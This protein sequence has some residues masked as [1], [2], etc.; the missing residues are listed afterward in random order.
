MSALTIAFSSTDNGFSLAI[1][2]K[3][4]Q[5]RNKNNLVSMYIQIPRMNANQIAWANLI[6][7]K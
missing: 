7:Q 3:I 6:T 1:L 5:L 2:K 4:E